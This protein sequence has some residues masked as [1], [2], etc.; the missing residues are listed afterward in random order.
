[1]SKIEI[2]YHQNEGK[3]ISDLKINYVVQEPEAVIVLAQCLILLLRKAGLTDDQMAMWFDATV[4]DDR[5]ALM[6][7]MERKH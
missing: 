4:H 1:M 6:K 5:L 7:M 2:G 3:L